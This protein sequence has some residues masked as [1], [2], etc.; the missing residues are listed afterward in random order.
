MNL[1]PQGHAVGMFR[2]ASGGG[3]EF[4]A[5]LTLPYKDDFHSMPMHGQF[6]LV[7]LAN[8]EEAVLGRITSVA[9]QGKLTSTAGEEYGLRAVA[10]DRQIPEDLRKRYLRYRIDIRMLGV[11]RCEDDDLI[12]A[13]SHRRLPH[14]GAK[15]A[16]LPDD[17]L[18]RVAGGTEGAEIGFYALGEFVYCGKGE[19]VD[20]PRW[21][22]DL[23]PRVPVCF[24]I[25]KLVARRSFIFARA[26]FGKSNLVKLL[27][28]GLYSERPRIE[29]RD[30]RKVPVGTIIFDPDGEYFWPDLTGRPALCDVDALA[31]EIVVFTNREAPSSF[32][33]SFKAGG[34]RLDIRQLPASLVVSIALSPE[35][36]RQQNVLKLKSLRGNVWREL[37][38]LIHR[39]RLGADEEEVQRLL[40]LSPGQESEL[41]AARA[42]MT[43][44]V[45]ELHDP[46]S[47]MLTLLERALRDGKLCIVDISRM[48][49]PAGLALSGIIL[50]H[51]FNHNQD[52]FTRAKPDPI[53]TIAVVEEAQSVLGSYGSGDSAY[54][55][56]IKE[57]RK[58]N[59]GAVLITQQPSSI[60]PELLSQG[61]SWFI[62]HLL[63]QGDLRAVKAANSHFSDDLLSSLL[64]EPLPGN[65]VFWSSVSGDV[66]RAGNAYPI[67][68][69]V[70]SFEQATSIKDPD[71]TGTAVEVYASELARSSERRVEEVR[72][73][74]KA[75]LAPAEGDDEERI[76][77]EE[78]A[79]ETPADADDTSDDAEDGLDLDEL[80]RQAAIEHLQDDADFKR[81][82]GRGNAIPWRGIQEALKRGLPT[83]G[84]PEPDRWAYELVP[85]ALERL[86]GSQDEAWHTERRPK[87]DDPART[88]LWVVIESAPGSEGNT[89]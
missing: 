43:R 74:L 49:G 6:V 36:Q 57:G 12:F 21:M 41:F 19:E 85:V 47:Q 64:N 77:S 22:Q 16:F 26:G 75:R 67:P 84:V 55:E 89:T 3:L 44:I 70:L 34:I 28:A 17:I 71:G 82:L 66:D 35:Q 4:H 30:G 10:D 20:K 72:E 56:W 5:D 24:A 45:G 40:G 33:G 50:R 11:L 80:Y 54:E 61:D 69:R 52:E 23:D 14:V 65:G 25:E 73:K 2:G 58:Y 9:A 18:C 37:V 88:V 53:P 87:K 7:E 76:V 83:D 78:A 68:L 60:P 63:S 29:M 42:N 31:N 81:W 59:L 8:P 38:D 51:I 27:F 39:D 86:Y 48:R 13:P 32:Y 46:A 79:S 62:F 1:F 15:V